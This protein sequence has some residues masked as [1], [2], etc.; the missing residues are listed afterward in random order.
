MTADSRAKTY[1]PDLMAE[2]ALDFIRR[3][4]DRPFFLYYAT[5]VP[6]AALQVPEKDLAAYRGAWKETPYRGDK[7]YLPHPSPRGLR[8]HGGPAWIGPWAG[9]SISWTSW[10]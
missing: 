8:G 1:A 6:H 7:G 2:E 9:W 4:K 10:T 3:E 5:P